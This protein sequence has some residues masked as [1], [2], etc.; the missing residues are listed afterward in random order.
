MTYPDVDRRKYPRLSRTFIV[1]YRVFQEINN[2][3]LTQ[4]K[5]VSVGGMLLTT[6]RKFAPG[7]VLAVDI[8]LPFL[9][10]PLNLKGRVIQSKEVVKNLIYDTHLEIIEADDETRGA[11]GETI[12]YHLKHDEGK[13]EKG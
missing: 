10:E 11:I 2:Y 6:N 8:R 7:T 5:N 9:M 1:S 3:D 12:V 4:T 13:N